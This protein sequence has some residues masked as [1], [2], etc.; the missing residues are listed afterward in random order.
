MCGVSRIRVRGHTW[1]PQVNQTL[2]YQVMNSISQSKA[3]INVMSQTLII[4]IVKIQP[5]LRW[6]S[7]CQC[8]QQSFLYELLEGFTQRH[9]QLGKLSHMFLCR[10]SLRLG[11]MSGW[12]L[13]GLSSINWLWSWVYICERHRSRKVAYTAHGVMKGNKLQKSTQLSNN[14]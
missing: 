12:P 4:S 1:L 14:I 10:W 2:I 11:I 13:C 9:S 8:S 7:R 3:T 6:W 5:E